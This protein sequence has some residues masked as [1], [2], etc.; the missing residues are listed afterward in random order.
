LLAHE[1]RQLDI[2]PGLLGGLPAPV[3]PIL[4]SAVGDLLSGLGLAK[5]ANAKSME[6]MSAESGTQLSDDQI[7]Q[8]KD[9]VEQASSALRAQLGTA[10]GLVPLPVAPLVPVTPLTPALP[11]NPPN[12]P[13]ELPSLGLPGIPLIPALPIGDALPVG[14][15][16]PATGS[17]PVSGLLPN[18]VPKPL[19]RR[20]VPSAPAPLPVGAL[21]VAILPGALPALSPLTGAIPALPLAPPAKPS[22]AGERRGV[23]PL[24]DHLI[25]ALPVPIPALPIAVPTLPSLV[26]GVA[27]P[28]A[29]DN[30]DGEDSGEDDDASPA[31]TGTAPLGGSTT[32]TATVPSTSA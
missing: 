21:P 5:A 1:R 2:I 12:T 26:P 10:T 6:S 3:G 9:V 29:A 15:L 25:P 11:A 16:L 22:A 13:R 27:L 24:V 7:A 19:N 32:S 4:Q 8:V 17:L 20:A 30:D 31:V 28:L 23:P 14:G 18:L